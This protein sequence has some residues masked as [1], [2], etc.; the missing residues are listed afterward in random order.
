MRKR[1]EQ[2]SESFALKR[3]ANEAL[4]EW[5]NQTGVKAILH[6]TPNQ[7]IEQKRNRVRAR[8]RDRE[9]RRRMSHGAASEVRHLHPSGELDR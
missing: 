6:K 3:R 4:A 8:I 1:V 7:L 5:K 9:E 2:S